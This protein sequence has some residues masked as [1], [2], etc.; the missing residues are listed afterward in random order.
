MFVF[1]MESVLW[2]LPVGG[3]GLPTGSASQLTT[4]VSDAPSWAGDSKTVLYLSNGKLQTVKVNGKGKPRESKP[5][6]DLPLTWVNARAPTG[7]SSTPAGCGTALAAAVRENVDILVQNHRIVGIEPHRAGRPGQVVDASNRFVMPGIIDIHH[8][9]EMQG[10]SYGSRQG[11]LWLALGIT[12]TRSPGSPA[13]HMV[14][15]RESVQSGK[16]VAPRY[17][18]TV[19]PSTARASTTTSCDRR[20]AR[21]S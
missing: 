21:D 9:R 15:E 12:T 13:Y 2:V 14:E 1:A 17:F 4:D 16:R 19:R 11:P 8:H 20:S 10:Y 3:D 18:G 7:S 5:R 6:I